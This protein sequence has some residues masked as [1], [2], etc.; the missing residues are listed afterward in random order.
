M[1]V[2]LEIGKGGLSEGMVKEIK[3][4]L[5]LK[6]RIKVRIRKSALAAESENKNEGGSAPK[7]TDKKEFAEKMADKC[8]SKLL[9]VIG[10]VAWLERKEQ[11]KAKA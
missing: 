1:D 10:F 6:K 8:G 7:A 4:Q 11:I 9:K 5:T 2:I 3:R